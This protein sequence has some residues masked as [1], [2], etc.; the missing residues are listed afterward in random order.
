MVTSLKALDTTMPEAIIFPFQET[1][2]T[3]FCSSCFALGFLSLNG[4]L[5]ISGFGCD[6]CRPE[7][8]FTF[9]RA[10]SPL[11]V[12]QSKNT[13]SDAKKAQNHVLS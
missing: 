6:L 12:L 3:P 13:E 10:N 4:N 9:P 5:D 1:T 2:N 8:G 7:P 11:L